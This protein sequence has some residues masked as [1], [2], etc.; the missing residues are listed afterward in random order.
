MKAFGENLGIAFQIKDDLLDYI[1]A[2]EE[3]GKPTG[4]DIRENKV[5]LPL[6]F[7]LANSPRE[8]RNAMLDKL[9]EGVKGEEEIAEVVKFVRENGGIDYSMDTAN[10]YGQKAIKNLKKYSDSELTPYLRELV[11]FAINREK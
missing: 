5:T 3:L 10:I 11:G 7:A 4:N 2:E 8:R 1:G 6:I 9:D